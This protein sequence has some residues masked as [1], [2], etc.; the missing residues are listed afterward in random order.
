ME[1]CWSGLSGAP[2]ERVSDFP[3]VGSNPTLSANGMWKES[4]YIRSYMKLPALDKKLNIYARVY[5]IGG[6]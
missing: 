1:R 5:I 4:S 2:G 6:D 3:T